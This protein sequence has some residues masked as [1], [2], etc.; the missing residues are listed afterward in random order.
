MD[1]VALFFTNSTK[2]WREVAI[3]M[4]QHNFIELAG[5]STKIVL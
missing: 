1:P 5:M 2:I 3:L 4:L